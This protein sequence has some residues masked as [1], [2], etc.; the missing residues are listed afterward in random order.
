MNKYFYCIDVGGLSIKAGIVDK[1]G[2]ILFSDS[3]KTSPAGTNYLAESIIILIEK[4]EKTSSM[5]IN[6]SSGLAI[7]LPG[8]ID[9]ENGVLKYSGNLKLKDYPIKSELQKKFKVP[10]K[11]ENDAGVATLAEM[12]FG[13]AKKHS[14]FIMLTVGTGIGGGIVLNGSLITK[15]SP[16]ACEIGHIKITR[17]KTKCS[18]GDEKC[19][20]ALASTKALVEKTKQAMKNNPKS[21]MWSKYTPDTA[22]GKTIFEFLDT[23]QTAKEIFDEYIT[24]LGDGIVS[25]VNIFAPEKVVIGGAISAQKNKLVLPLEKYVNQHIYAKNGGYKVKLVSDKY[26]GNAGI[27]GGICLFD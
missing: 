16:F 12:R 7:G 10:I 6:K 9:R 19:W 20:E 3:I 8:I 1:N 22:S 5:P 4:L 14:N 17:S 21:K 26:T 24:N 25:L 13:N 18:C 23:D 15:A 27:I 11:I 2:T